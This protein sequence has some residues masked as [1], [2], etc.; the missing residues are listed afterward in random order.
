MY[1]LQALWTQA[2]EDLDVTTVI[3]N[4]HAYAIL[5]MELARVGAGEP[6]PKALAM[7]DL[8]GPDLDFAKL[9]AGM[10]VPGSRPTTAEEFTDAF[11]LAL[12]EP[13]P[14]LIEVAL[15]SRF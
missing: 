7:L 13:G 10:G 6:G 5:N 1:T 2:R 8:H 4:N 9:A 3:F 12:A 14:Y 15:E 11:E